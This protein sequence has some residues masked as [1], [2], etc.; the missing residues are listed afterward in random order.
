[1]L[2]SVLRVTHTG[3]TDEREVRA[4]FGFC[5]LMGV[6]CE[7]DTWDDWSRDELLHYVSIANKISRKRFEEISW[8]LHFDDNSLLPKREPGFHRL[9]KVK[10]IVD[11]VRAHFTAIYCPRRCKSKWESEG[12]QTERNRERK[13]DRKREGK[14]KGGE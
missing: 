12:K 14:G 4:Y 9:Q 8:Y 3:V 11:T 2:L 5:I 1:M 10:R 6:V 13:R 7:S